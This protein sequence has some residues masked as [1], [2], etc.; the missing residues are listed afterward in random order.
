MLQPLRAMLVVTL[1]PSQSASVLHSSQEHSQRKYMMFLLQERPPQS[2]HQS[3]VTNQP[4]TLDSIH[5]LQCP[6]THT[7]ALL[8]HIGMA[9]L[10][11]CPSTFC[12]QHMN[13]PRWRESL[14]TDAVSPHSSSPIKHL[15]PVGLTCC[16]TSSPPGLFSGT[17]NSPLEPGGETCA[18]THYFQATSLKAGIGWYRS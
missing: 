7:Q 2:R 8:S 13:S 1:R 6:P 9:A 5:P 18:G 11:D 4:A 12:F 15:G 17:V 14:T 10:D 16:M 3:P